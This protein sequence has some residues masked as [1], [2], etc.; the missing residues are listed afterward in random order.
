MSTNKLRTAAALLL[1]PG[2]TVHRSLLVIL[3]DEQLLP[4]EDVG[5]SDGDRVSVDADSGTIT[6]QTTGATYQAQPFPEF[7]REIIEAGGLVERTKA[8]FAG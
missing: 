7:I 6:N 1:A 4:G 2:G 3:N 8:R 5:L